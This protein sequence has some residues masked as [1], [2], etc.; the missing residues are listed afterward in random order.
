VGLTIAILGG[1]PASLGGGGLE[2]QM[3]QT[4]LALA[5]RGHAVFDVS[6][7][8]VPREFDIL[9]AFGATAN[10][11]HAL[12]HWNRSPSPLV[13]SPVTPIGSRTVRFDRLAA[14]VPMRSYYSSLRLAWLRRA[15]S[16]I[17]L[18]QAEAR[19]MGDIGASRVAVIPNGVTPIAVGSLP[20]GSP[21]PGTFVLLL[22]RI[23]G[24]K[25]QTSALQA[26]AGIPTVIVGG[27][28]G[29]AQEHAEFSKEVER[30]GVATWLGEITDQAQV[31]ALIAGAKALV[32]LTR[33]EGQSLSILEA[34]SV[35]TPVVTTSIPSHIE[36]DAAYPGCLRFVRRSSELATAI[37]HVYGYQPVAVP[38]W[39]DVAGM[40]ERE[41]LHLLPGAVPATSTAT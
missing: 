34:L 22:G 30:H 37:E 18:T 23:G 15:A 29:S 9:H 8:E 4:M 5:R 40:L 25:G 32:Q 24:W 21:E 17:A 28:A 2:V 12:T 35:G 7:E 1:V 36:L 20:V 38:T 19:L 16:V 41:Y 10:V 6:A 39:D 3:R 14:R 33:R 11:V 26:L 31:R 13:V 27:L